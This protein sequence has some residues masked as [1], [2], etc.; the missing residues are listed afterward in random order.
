MASNSCYFFCWWLVA[1]PWLVDLFLPSPD[2][3]P[4]PPSAAA[5]FAL[6]WAFRI[7]IFLYLG[8]WPAPLCCVDVSSHQC[9]D[10]RPHPMPRSICPTY[11]RSTCSSTSLAASD[12]SRGRFLPAVATSFPAW[13]FTRRVCGV[14]GCGG[15]RPGQS[16]H[17]SELHG[18]RDVSDGRERTSRMA[19]RVSSGSDSKTSRQSCTCHVGAVG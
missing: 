3:A 11:S 18:K 2:H 10:Q 14:R 4:P 15:H 1:F 9:A 19:R 7:C 5:A 17:R 8:T 13:Y 16:T 6:A 12:P